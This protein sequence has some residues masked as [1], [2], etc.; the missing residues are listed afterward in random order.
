MLAR[1]A[2]YRFVPLLPAVD[3]DGAPKA[4]LLLPDAGC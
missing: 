4:F 2:M 3:M 1:A